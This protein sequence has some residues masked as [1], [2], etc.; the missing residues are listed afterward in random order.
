[1]VESR[2]R[3]LRLRGADFSEGAEFLGVDADGLL[4][5]ALGGGAAG[6]G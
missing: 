3:V 2:D 1:M 4:S 6:K 5:D